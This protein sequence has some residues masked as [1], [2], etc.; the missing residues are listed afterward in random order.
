MKTISAIMQHAAGMASGKIAVAA[1]HDD[2]V[3]QAVVE[4]R[5]QKIA[6]SVLVGDA[7]KIT[8]MLTEMGENPADYEIIAA[9]DDVDCAKKAVACVVEGRAGFLMKGLLGTATLMRAVLDKE[10]GLRTGRLITAVGRKD[11]IHMQLFYTNCTH[12][13]NPF[14]SVCQSP[15]RMIS[16]FSSEAGTSIKR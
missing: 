13:L 12:F 2:A 9:A 16:F 7:E 14:P 5:R 6:Q 1:A 15:Q 8:T 4:A 3:I 11:C 10:V